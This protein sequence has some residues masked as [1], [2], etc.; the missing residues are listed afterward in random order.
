MIEL[1]QKALRI[2]PVMGHFHP[3][4][5]LCLSNEVEVVNSA[6][7]VVEQM[8]AFERHPERPILITEY[9]PRYVD[10]FLVQHLADCPPA[11]VVNLALPQ[12]VHAARHLLT[13]KKIAQ[14]IVADTTA[15]GYE[16]VAL[17]LVDGLS[18][19]DVKHWPEQP[20]SC[21]IDGPSIT[22]TLQ[23]NGTVQQDIGF[24]GIIGQPSL[25][26]QLASAGIPHS[27]GYSYWERERNEVSAFLFSGMPLTRVNGIG[28]ALEILKK[29]KLRGL[30]LQLVREGT[31]GLA[32]QRREVTA[33]EVQ[34]TVEAIYHD[35]RQLVRLLA[36]S[37]VKGAVYLVAD[38]G[39]LW[40]HQHDFVRL[41]GETAAHVRYTWE[42]P[43]D[44]KYSTFITMTRPCYLYHYPYIGRNIRANDSGVHGGLS[45]WESIVPFIRVEVNV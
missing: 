45:Y 27:R 18:Y 8:D 36:E 28:E 3:L 44:E 32:H 13:H 34:A 26:R 23:A 14:R 11:E 37:E 31:D 42:R 22:Y 33:P 12:R 25:A 7:L 15:N 41:S 16:T 4:W 17:M 40:K 29:S 6:R 1:L 43:L 35:F 20:L 24:P 2:A 10:R 5:A 30:Y 39:I 9:L 21:F 19:D 38:H